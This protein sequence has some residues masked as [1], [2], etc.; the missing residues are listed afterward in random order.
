MLRLAIAGQVLAL[1]QVGPGF[2]VLKDFANVEGESGRLDVII[3]Q[4]VASSREVFLPHG[5]QPDSK[6]AVYF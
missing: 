6:R 2:V 1:S 3:D 5:I 4:R